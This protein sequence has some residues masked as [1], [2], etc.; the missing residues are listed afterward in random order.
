MGLLWL[1]DYSPVLQR[2]LQTGAKRALGN[3]VVAAAKEGIDPDKHEDQAKFTAF[4]QRM[5]DTVNKGAC[6]PCH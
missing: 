1:R 5:L 6:T 3:I 4:I 2:F